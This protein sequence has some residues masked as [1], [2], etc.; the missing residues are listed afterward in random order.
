MLKLKKIHILGFK[1]F[2]DRTEL[3]VPGTGIA[4]VVGP[5]GCGKSNILDGVSWV[6]GEQSAKSLRGT[7]MQDVIFAGTRDRKPL[8]MAEVT[9]T[10]VDPEAYEGPIPVEPEVSVEPDSPTD[11]DEDEVRRE[12]AAEAEEII[13]AEQPGQTLDEDGPEPAPATA[14]AGGPQAVV[15]K[16]R[17]RKFQRTPQKGE[18]V[19]TRRLFRTG[20]SEYLLN[21]KL[22]RLRDIQDIFMGTGLGPES[23]AIIG[24]E[25]IGQLLSSK[26][27]DRR[28]IIEEAAGITRFKTKK[29]LAELR[30]ESAKQNLA[31][32]DDI[33]E[34]VTRQMNSLKRQA[35]KAERF[36]AVRDELRD[37]LRVVLASRMAMMDSEQARLD[38]E[39][40]SLSERINSSAAEIG[41]LEGNQ[42]SL[43]ERGYELDREGQEAQNRA[44][45]AAV[46]LERA[47]ARERANTERVSDLEGRISAAA[48]ELDVTRTQLAGIAEERAQQHAFLETAAGEARAFRQKVEASQREA[49][50]AAEEVFA[51][52][53]Q[54]ESTRRHVM[55]LLTLAGNARNHTAQ[56]EESLAALER[57]AQRLNAEMGQAR[58]EQENLGVES[59]QVKLRFESAADALKRLENE[60]AALRESLQAKRAEENEQRSRANQMHSE[61]AA[62]S[63][64]RDSL[65]A[66]IRNH[67]YSTDTVRR[68]LKP[69]ALG[70]GMAPVGTLADF[71]EVSGEHEGVVDEFLREELNYVVVESWVA[72]EEGVRLLKSGVDGRAT[73]LVHPAEQGALFKEDADPIAETGVTPLKDSIRVLNGLGRSLESILPKLRHGYL[74][75][76]S[77]QAQRLAAQ[78]P[79]AFFLTVEGECFHNATVTG[80]KPASE[81]PLALKRELREAENRLGKLETALAQAEMEAAALTRT[82]EELATQL[83]V[84][85]AERRQAETEA[86]NQG[87]ALKQ[88][89]SEVQRVERRLQEWTLQAARNKDAREAKHASIDQK[90]EETARL[91]AEHAQSEAS[92]DELQAQLAMTREKREGLQQ[93]AAQV[94]AELAGLEERRRGAEAAFQRIDRLHA[95]LERRV[96]SIEQQR[97]AAEVEREQR[98]GESAALASRQK[99]LADVRAE[100]LAL[101]QTLASQSQALRQ[102][103]STIETQLKTARAALDQLREDRG[104][105]SSLVAKLRSDL[106][107]LEASCLAEVNV[108]AQVLRADETIVRLADEPLAA[109]EE[110]C[111]TLRQ[112]IEQMGPVNMMALDEYKETAERHSFL[113][114]QRK[115]LIESIENTQETIKEI[116]Q[117]SRTKF[118]EAFARIN[119]NFAQVFS[120][121]FQG[122]QAF[123]RLTDAENQA[124]SGLEI[125]A[126]PPGKKLQNVLLLSG[127]EKALTALALLVGIFQFQPS[128]FCVL[129]E[130]DAPLDETNVGRLA[131]LLHSLSKE[132]QFLLVTHSKRM[133]Q[134]ADMIYGVTMQEPGVSKVVSVRLGSHEQQ[135]ATA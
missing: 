47:T 49:R 42:H 118:D 52:E 43:T 124:E 99:E 8:G 22:C 58:N 57:E 69:G 74:V 130:V 51:A 40:A 93:E 55:H 86:A 121:L 44:S 80:G 60:I 33:F 63:G 95:D 64:R 34:E 15:L 134:S 16:I 98:I 76:D 39:I 56:A 116:D 37:R 132:T 110:T 17:R 32:V 75:E 89:E 120:R 107:Y 36:A 109:E 117:I 90:R 67:S 103:L 53:R 66:L 82:I 101:A 108:E 2:C 71:L 23:Y 111:R 25:R 26:P 29:R 11:W 77:T 73:F 41:A 9:L 104:N 92:L 28:A 96:Q 62:I 97:A 21:G 10:M 78:H 131:D 129:D 83:E 91:E 125:V 45:E 27:H 7:H 115:D 135:R 38:Q 20:E 54:L 133:M 119:E 59:G 24:Q 48:A 88:M 112:R 85:S 87:A 14:E 84:S 35:A 114:T 102:Q 6:L 72:A 79:L 81:G 50:T 4:V 1:S 5:N 126:S 123:L 70:Q 68:L 61:Q 46:E 3:T 94:T 127:G 31:R 18:I 105:R 106:E 30:L 122:G 12:R 19:I 100:A 13:A 65:E 113:E 128:P